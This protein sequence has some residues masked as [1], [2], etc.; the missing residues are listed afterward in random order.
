[1]GGPYF[2]Y[3]IIWLLFFL[4]IFLDRVNTDTYPS[5]TAYWLNML[6]VGGMHGF[7]AWAQFTFMRDLVLW[8]ELLHYRSRV[9]NEDEITIVADDDTAIE[10]SDD[11]L[12]DE[13]LSF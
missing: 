2:L 11:I 1:M 4:A 5:R 6:G 9:Y 10:V 3:E 8:E 7:T 12:A 13:G